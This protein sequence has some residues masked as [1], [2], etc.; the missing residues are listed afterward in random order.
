MRDSFAWLRC[1]RCA[2]SFAAQ[3][4]DSH[5]A[6]L[7][8]DCNVY[9]V[10]SEIP[11]LLGG[12]TAARYAGMIEQGRGFD[13][14]AMALRPAPSRTFVRRAIRRALR[15]G[16]SSNQWIERGDVAGVKRAL[17]RNRTFRDFLAYY[18][19]N[20]GWGS[21][22][23]FHYFYNRRSD[24]GFVAAEMALAPLLETE[25]TVLDAACGVGH[26][27]RSLRNHIGAQR[28]VAA[29]AVFPMLY[30]AKRFVA[31]GA[32]YVCASLEQSLPF[33]TDAF[34]GA[35]CSDALHDVT[36]TAGF[37]AELQRVVEPR[38]VA[39][40]P[41]CHNAT[42]QH[43]YPG[44]HPLTPSG[45][46]SAFGA[47]R[48]RIYDQETFLGKVVNGGDLDL[49]AD[50]D[51]AVLANARDLVLMVSDE[52]SNFRRYPAPPTRWPRRP[53]FSTLLDAEPRKNEVRLV[54]RV[55]SEGEYTEIDR[56]IPSEIKLPADVLDRCARRDRNTAPLLRRGILLDLPPDYG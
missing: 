10:L 1:P 38:G 7:R 15:S 54:R 42:A 37:A 53:R 9:P 26:L 47:D 25:G 40:L 28:I 12:P 17:Q 43:K 32:R 45:Y 6:L 20:S 56:T 3:W 39:M 52:A 27:T 30:L 21:P 29:D 11:I 31:P 23:T 5:S 51:D 8:C 33:P 2:G 55:R 41:H 18:Y 13:A 44:A 35:L 24:P 19:L 49:L 36:G 50:P 46:R 4:K 16:S 14:L 22:G 34:T 48:T